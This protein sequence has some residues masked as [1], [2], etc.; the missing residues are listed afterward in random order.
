M[1]RKENSNVIYAAQVAA[2]DLLANRHRHV[3]EG[4]VQSDIETLIKAL[5]VGSVESHYQQGSE[6]AD[7]YLPNRRTFIECKAY[8]KAVDPDQAQSGRRESPRQQ[9]ERYIHA[10]I[11]FE[12]QQLPGVAQHMQ[13]APWRGIVTDGSNWHVYRYEHRVSAKGVLESSMR[14]SNEGDA[15][16]S[17]LSET[18]GPAV[19]KQWIPDK[20]AELFSDLKADLDALYDQLPKKADLPTRTKFHLWLDMMKTSGMVPADKTGQARLFLSHSFLIVVARF[21]SH[22]VTGQRRRA[23]WSDVLQDGFASWVLDFSRGQAWAERVWELVD[24]YDWRR[25]RGDVLRDLYHRYVSER[26]RQVFGEFYTPDWLAALMVEEVLDDEWIENAVYAAATGNV[27]GIGVLD[28]TCGSGTFLYHAARRILSSPSVKALSAVRQSDVVTRLVNG[29]DIHPVAVEMARVN[30]ERALPSE[31]SEGA[32]AFRVYLGDSLQVARRGDLLFSEEKDAMLLITPN[33]GRA[34]VPMSLVQSPSFAENMRLMVNAAVEREPL[35]SIV[36]KNAENRA[37]LEACHEA[38]TAI[39]K[40]EGN[41]VWTWYAV[42]LAGPHLLAQRKVDRLVANPPWVK[43]AHI[44]VESRKREMEQVG[45]DLR[46]QAG[47]KQAPHLDIASYFVL[48]TRQLYAAD[49]DRNPG[50]WLLKKSAISSGQWAPFRTAHRQTLAQS[51]DLEA[52]NPFQGGDATRCCLLMEHRPMRGTSSPRMMAERTSQRRPLPHDTLGSARGKFKFG[53]AP[54]PLPQAPSDY[55]NE[56]IRQGATIVPHVL[57]LV[58]KSRKAERIGW[59]RIETLTSRHH[60]W[61]SVP[62]QSGDVPD[63]WIRPIH[64]SP[65]MLPYMAIGEPPHAVIPIDANGELNLR[66]GQECGFWEE[67]EEVYDAHKGQGRGTPQTLIEQ[68]DFARKLSAQPM[69]RQKGR[70]MVLYPGSG[71]NMRGA[72]THAGGAVVDSTLY[73]LVCRTEVEAGYLVALLNAGCLRR[74]FSE[75]KESGRHFNLFPWRKVPIPKFDPRDRK[76]N[77]LAQLCS[78]AERIA[79]RRVR[80]ELADRPDLGQP[81]LSKAVRAAVMESRTGRDIERLA[82][83]LLPEQAS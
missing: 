22:T 82:A 44:Q 24:S 7:I 77:R 21:V 10:E 36:E 42:N 46:L 68:V 78:E 73:W 54:E 25:R 37:A 61:K 45:K 71:D 79:E 8:P 48:L 60:P 28:P 17:F 4:N 26:D 59:T 12:S 1:K 20:P 52:L 62:S 32:S 41:S 18:L 11:E 66:P 65:D 19:G 34:H 38:L 29:L 83:Q 74:A 76:H 31:P 16:A 33:G 50:S 23:A 55:S 56:N 15:L 47:G 58:G 40:K 57:T 9:M 75:C 69:R 80:K 53:P 39:V 51:V 6:Q 27:D 5:D 30:I 72:R 67:L 63:S 70:R 14:F 3:A 43:L 13:D 64:T 81:G 35:P 2:R 49:P